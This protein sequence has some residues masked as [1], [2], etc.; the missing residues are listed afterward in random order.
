MRKWIYPDTDLLFQ[1]FL[2]NKAAENKINK[3][4]KLFIVQYIIYSIKIPTKLS[5]VVSTILIKKCFFAGH[6]RL[7]F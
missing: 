2:A 4:M 3:Q 6:N 1:T 5:I 7:V